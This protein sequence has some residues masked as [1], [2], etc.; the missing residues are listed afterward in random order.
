MRQQGN[1]NRRHIAVHQWSN[2]HERLFKGK[3]TNGH[4][5]DW[6]WKCGNT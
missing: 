6:P 1:S 3:E 2:R 5:L 4:G